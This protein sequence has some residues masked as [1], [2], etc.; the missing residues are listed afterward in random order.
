MCPTCDGDVLCYV[1]ENRVKC[2]I[3]GRYK[4]LKIR[5]VRIGPTRESSVKGRLYVLR[6]IQMYAESSQLLDDGYT[7]TYSLCT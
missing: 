1:A 3:S 6:S 5:T 4:S 7:T 2:Q